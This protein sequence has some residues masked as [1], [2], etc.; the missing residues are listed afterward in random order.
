MNGVEALQAGKWADKFALAQYV[1]CAC[2]HVWS[3]FLKI[4][5][6]VP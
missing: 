4:W 5:P 3:W 1:T 2:A 6:F